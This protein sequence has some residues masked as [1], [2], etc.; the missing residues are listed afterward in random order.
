MSW[1]DTTFSNRMELVCNGSKEYLTDFAVKIKLDSTNWDF[2]VSDTDGEDVR[3]IDTDD[4]TALDFWIEDFDSSGSTGT[5][6]IKIPISAIDGTRT[7]YL[8]YGKAGQTTAS[9]PDNTLLEWHAFDDMADYSETGPGT[10]GNY[11]D[12]TR[13]QVVE[14]SDDWNQK[15]TVYAASTVASK[16]IATAWINHDPSSSGASRWPGI[17]VEMSDENNFICY[18]RRS[19]SAAQYEKDVV[20]GS[21]AN[22]SKGTA[23]AISANAWAKDIVIVKPDTDWADITTIGSLNY[24]DGICTDGT[25]LWCT[26]A[27]NALTRYDLSGT[28]QEQVTIGG[29]GTAGCYYHATDGRVYVWVVSSDTA[30]D[31][32]S[33]DAY[34]MAAGETLHKTFTTDFASDDGVPGAGVFNRGYWVVG[35]TTL[36]TPASYDHRWGIYDADWAL[37]SIIAAH[38]YGGLGPNDMCVREDLICATNHGN[39]PLTMYSF[40]PTHLEMNPVDSGPTGGHQGI[41]WDSVN[42]RWMRGTTSGTSTGVVTLSTLE[43][44][45]NLRYVGTG[46]PGVGTT[47]NTGLHF[48]QKDSGDRVT[49]ARIGFH[50]RR[51][52]RFNH[53]ALHK[54]TLFRPWFT[55][56]GSASRLSASAPLVPR[57]GVS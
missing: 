46:E 30:S 47:G 14:V 11:A 22:A 17:C 31:V 54:H 52:S 40:D 48:G 9:D 56:T 24:N 18:T 6:W 10:W 12:A 38:D 33:V 23:P 45:A 32:R 7:V 28:Q 37:V 36:G 41:D 4:S 13:G 44:S 2:T 42:S 55:V 43:D 53:L 50:T 5:V 25:H 35:T 49:T 15:Q 29:S 26:G 19:D 39:N 21:E 20:A 27:S 34:D 51:T 1:W 3:A 8:Y 16:Y 57:L